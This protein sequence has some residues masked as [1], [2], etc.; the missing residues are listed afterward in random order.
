MAYAIK[1]ISGGEFFKRFFHRIVEI[2]TSVTIWRGI[3]FWN[4]IY[5]DHLYLTSFPGL[6]WI[7]TH[8]ANQNHVKAP[9]WG[10]LW[11]DVSSAQKS[12]RSTVLRKMR[13][14]V[15]PAHTKTYLHSN[16]FDR[17]TLGFLNVAVTFFNQNFTLGKVMNE[18][19]FYSMGF[20]IY[21]RNALYCQSTHNKQ[22]CVLCYER[23]TKTKRCQQMGLLL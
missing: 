5:N 1:N 4:V 3:W 16:P 2:L 13:Q 20:S 18:L 9:G 17:Y 19:T 22:K 23:I 15:S 14:P 10:S 8:Q 6:N 11:Q 12:Q 21:L 7:I